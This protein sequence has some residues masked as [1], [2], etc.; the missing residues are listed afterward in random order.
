MNT[1]SAQTQASRTYIRIWWRRYCC[2][3]HGGIVK[4]QSWY[5]KMTRNIYLGETQPCPDLR[6]LCL[7]GAS[8]SVMWRNLT[9]LTWNVVS[10]PL[11]QSIR[12]TLSRKKRESPKVSLQ[13]KLLCIVKNPWGEGLSWVSWSCSVHS[14]LHSVKETTLRPETQQL[15]AAYLLFHLPIGA[16]REALVLRRGEARR[17]SFRPSP[18][19]LPARR[20]HRGTR[21][22][23]D[24]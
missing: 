1:H 9:R 15:E 17:R 7:K 21:R 4:T 6:S 5:N 24:R 16:R 14:V 12:D 11:W 3:S 18:S 22:N 10:P 19:S 23:R 2:E 8:C 13:K 20:P